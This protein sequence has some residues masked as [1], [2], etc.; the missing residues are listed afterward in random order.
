MFVDYYL[1]NVNAQID[2]VGYFSLPQELLDE[3]AQSLASF[4]VTQ[5]D[6]GGRGGRHPRWRQ[7]DG[8]SAHR[9]HG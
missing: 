2:E 6:P 8:L 7:F 9:A 4:G 3:Q 5:T 1:N